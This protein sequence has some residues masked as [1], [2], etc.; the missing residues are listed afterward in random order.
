MTVTSCD[1]DKCSARKCGR[2]ITQSQSTFMMYKIRGRISNPGVHAG[3]AARSEQSQRT[4]LVTNDPR[5]RD[6]PQAPVRSVPRHGHHRTATHPAHARRAGGAREG[7][8]GGL[9]VW[10]CSCAVG[11][12]RSHRSFY[13]R[14]PQGG[15]EKNVSAFIGGCVVVL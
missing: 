2:C 6:K 11:I 9:Q 14:T 15:I 1:R 8:A 10:H 13:R 4:P 5:S 7:K 12:C 3:T